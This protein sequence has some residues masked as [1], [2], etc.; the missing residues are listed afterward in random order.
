MSNLPIERHSLTAHELTIT[1]MLPAGTAEFVIQRQEK[2]FEKYSKQV[3][4][5]ICLGIMTRAFTDFSPNGMPSA[6]ILQFQTEALLIELKGKFGTMTASEI[7]AAFNRG[8]R[9]ESG[10][11]FGMC[12]MTYNQFLKWY[13]NLPERSA[14]WSKYLD[15]VENVKTSEKPVVLTKDFLIRAAKNAFEDYKK[16]GSLPIVPHSIYDTIKELM[17]VSTII[18]KK[19]W[20]NVSHEATEALKKRN[21]SRKGQK[22]VSEVLNRESRSWEFE[23]KKIALKMFFDDLINRNEALEL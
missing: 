12:P 6:Q 2:P 23:C 4:K 8:I 9:S 7:G 11:F 5:I 16:S 22:T 1:R 17:G 19:C 21:S 20:E 10:P 18:P 14:A 13:F 15:F 3:Q